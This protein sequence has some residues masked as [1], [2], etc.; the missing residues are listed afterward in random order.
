MGAEGGDAGEHN[1]GAVGNNVVPVGEDGI[2]GGGGH[3]AEGAARVG[4]AGEEEAARGIGGTAGMMID[5]IF[6]VVAAFVD[7]RELQRGAVGAEVTD[8]AGGVAVGD[9]EDVGAAAAAFDVNAEA[10][11]FFF[12]EE[13]VGAVGADYVE[14]EVV[15]AF[16]GFVLA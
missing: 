12:V 10:L 16:G 15:G 6:V 3:E 8:L 7:E 4:G 2:G 14:K 5:V 1:A 9:K 13:S 11:V